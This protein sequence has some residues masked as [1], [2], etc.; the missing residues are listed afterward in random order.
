[1]RLSDSNP[2]GAVLDVVTREM[3]AR[4]AHR[5]KSGWCSVCVLGDV[6]DGHHQI[7]FRVRSLQ[8]ANWDRPTIAIGVANARGKFNPGS[9]YAVGQT[10]GWAIWG[11]GKLRHAGRE[12]DFVDG[13]GR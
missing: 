8:Q 2:P 6:R 12:L 11:D 13:N 3:I 1:M 7:G 5:E 9:G 10:T 4:K